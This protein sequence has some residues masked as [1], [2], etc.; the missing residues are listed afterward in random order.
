MGSKEIKQQVEGEEEGR[1]L[2]HGSTS[3]GA[4]AETSRDGGGGSS[5]AAG[6]RRRRLV[7]GGRRGLAGLRCHAGVSGPGIDARQVHAR[8]R[9]QGVRGGR[10]R[11]LRG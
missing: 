10:G 9:P 1:G 11:A 6:K 7:A 2:T 5:L 4:R 8:V 3:Q